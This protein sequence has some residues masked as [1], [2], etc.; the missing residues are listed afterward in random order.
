MP[1][2]VYVIPGPDDGKDVEEWV[3]DDEELEECCC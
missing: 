1:V 3:E 2:Q